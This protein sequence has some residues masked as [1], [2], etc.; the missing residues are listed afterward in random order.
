[1]IADGEGIGSIDEDDW[2]E[3]PGGDGA[4]WYFTVDS[5]ASGTALSVGDADLDVDEDPNTN[6]AKGDAYDEG[7]VLAVG[8]TEFSPTSATAASPEAV[9]TGAVGGLNTRV[10]YRPMQGSATI[11]TLFTLTNPGSEAV[12]TTASLLTNVGSDSSTGVR[13]TSSGDTTF[14][15]ED[16]WIVTSDN[17]TTP[18]DPVNTHVLYGPGSPRVKPSSVDQTVFDSAT[19]HGVQAD[20]PIT[21]PAGG[22]VSLLFFNDLSATNDAALTNAGR[23]DANPAPANELV[24]DLSDAELASIVNWSLAPVTLAKAATSAAAVPRGDNGY[25]VTATNPNGDA[26]SVTITDTL[27]VGFS[28]RAGTATVDGAAVAD[29][30]IDGQKLTFG[31]VAVP[32]AGSSTLRFGVR[33]SDKQ[34][35]YAN[36]VSG[37]SMVGS[38]TAAPSTVAVPAR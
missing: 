15:V 17:A 31:A 11:R 35:T 32:A 8:G 2:E 38:A 6:N 27:P 24:A 20:F 22:T 5:G 1:V 9:G 30:T 3:L 29:P 19:T 25:A 34:G 7:M 36:S 26:V 18:S 23:F 16:R 13:G 28:Y 14:T 4:L 37:T 10:E 33:V 21:V 12:T